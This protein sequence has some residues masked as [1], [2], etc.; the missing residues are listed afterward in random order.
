MPYSGFTFDTVEA[1]LG[2][3]IDRDALFPGLTGVAAP[4]WLAPV[5]ANGRSLALQNE[6]S[7]SEFIVAPVLLAARELTGDAVA[8]YSGQSLDIDAKRELF[9][10]CDFI[11]A[12]APA[13]PRLRAP[14]LT[15]VGAKRNDIEL[16]LG[17]VI[18]QMVGAAEFNRR[19]DLVRPIYGCVTTGEDWQFLNLDGSSVT[20][21][22][23]RYYINRV[24]LILAAL[25]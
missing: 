7:R 25:A 12:R 10:E 13:L 8:I 14:L 20:F 2:L 16:G 1:E 5:L 9:G 11:V 21:D 4:A 6:K 18:A 19:A 15:L 23:E 22:T 24:D 3:V 17:Q